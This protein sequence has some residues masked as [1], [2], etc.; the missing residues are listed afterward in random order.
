M[1]GRAISVSSFTLVLVAATTFGVSGCGSDSE[2]GVDQ[3][4]DAAAIEAALKKVPEVMKNE[5]FTSEKRVDSKVVQTSVIDMKKGILR[6][7][8]VVPE[9]KGG[10]ETVLRLNPPMFAVKSSNGWKKEEGPEVGSLIKPLFDQIIGNSFEITT[11]S[12]VLG[13]KT[14]SGNNCREAQ[15][16]IRSSSITKLVDTITKRALNRNPKTAKKIKNLVAGSKISGTYCLDD[17]GHIYSAKSKFRLPALAKERFPNAYKEMF[18]QFEKNLTYSK[19]GET[20][21]ELPEGL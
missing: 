10:N 9:D 21:V 15:I 1:F 5:S 11:V 18:K 2:A 14:V 13:T 4:K 8:S 3:L 19:W 20:T 12:K 6:I 7:K 17:S 16:A